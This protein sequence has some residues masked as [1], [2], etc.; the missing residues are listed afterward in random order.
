MRHQKK[1]DFTREYNHSMGMTILLS[2]M[3]AIQDDFH[4]VMKEIE[5]NVTPFRL[6][7]VVS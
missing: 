1:G 2:C 6:I 3:K 4:L 5:H 7:D